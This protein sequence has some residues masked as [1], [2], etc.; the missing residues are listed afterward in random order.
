M[1]LIRTVNYKNCVIKILDTGGSRLVE[2]YSNNKNLY[3]LDVPDHCGSWATEQIGRAF[4]DGLKFEG[5]N[6][7]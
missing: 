5:K 3:D 2:V 6:N 4:V 7:D 1:Y